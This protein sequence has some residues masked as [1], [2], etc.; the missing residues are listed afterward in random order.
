M[1]GSGFYTSLA[2]LLE[3][4]TED[5]RERLSAC[6]AMIDRALGDDRAMMSDCRKSFTPFERAV[7]SLSTEEAQELYTRTFDISPVASLE[8]G[9]HLYGEA[10]ERG[11]FLVRMR[12]LLRS[13]GIQEAT[14]LPDH[15]SYLLCA[16]ERLEAESATRIVQTYLIPAVEKMLAGFKDEANPYRHLL[17]TIEIVLHHHHASFMGA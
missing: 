15:L 4:P 6:V 7:S 12:E 8:V 14:E 16:V 3:Y 13:V 2:R 17:E 1:N 9:W 11:A 10:Y 5:F